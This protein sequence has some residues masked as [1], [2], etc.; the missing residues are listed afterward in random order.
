MPG[1]AARAP[2]RARPGRPGPARARDDRRLR[3]HPAHRPGR[4]PRRR[5]RRLRAAGRLAG[6]RGIDIGPG[7]G[8]D[9]GPPGAGASPR[10]SGLAGRPAARRSTAAP[11]GAVVAASRRQVPGSRSSATVAHRSVA[12]TGPR[13]VARTCRPRR[14]TTTAGT[15]VMRLVERP[16]RS[17]L[18]APGRRRRRPPGGG[19]CPTPP[20][21]RARRARTRPPAT[22]PP[23]GRSRPGPGGGAGRGTRWSGPAAA[24]PLDHDGGGHRH[25]HQHGDER[26]AFHP[27]MVVPG[28]A[29]L[30]RRRHVQEGRPA[31]WAW[32]RSSLHRP[33]DDDRR[34][35]PHHHLGRRGQVGV[36]RT[37]TG[38]PAAP[39]PPSTR[40]TP[41]RRLRP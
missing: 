17:H 33:L 35:G 38:R 36:E 18:C 32:R 21:R 19:P 11:S 10:R 13:N 16:G 9:V 24:A 8:P 34:P 4:G 1:D 22:G 26:E 41:P 28:R 5:Q 27:P 23:G 3:G 12:V 14:A 37:S 29:R 15:A 40:S 7:V 39:V 25:G 31:P 30:Q 20:A 2:Q 6:E